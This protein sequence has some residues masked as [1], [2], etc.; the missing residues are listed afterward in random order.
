MTSWTQYPP[1]IQF[2]RQTYQVLAGSWT[3]NGKEIGAPWEYKTAEEHLVYEHVFTAGPAF[4]S[5][6]VRTVL[7]FEAV[8]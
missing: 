3:L 5:E 4:C 8:D 2:K 7:H 1:R 6:A